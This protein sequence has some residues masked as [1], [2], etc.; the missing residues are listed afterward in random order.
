MEN[1]TLYHHGI[2]GQKWGKRNGP[3]YPLKPEDH[4]KAEKEATK[5]K[6]QVSDN[7]KKAIKIGAAIVATGL[8]AY[9][10]YKVG[11][12]D[13][14]TAIGKQYAKSHELLGFSSDI[15]GQK[16]ERASDKVREALKDVNP[17]GERFHCAQNSL[18]SCIKFSG[19]KGLENIR[20]KPGIRLDTRGKL[21]ETCFLK[22]DGSPAKAIQIKDEI[23]TVDDAIKAI[24][25][26]FNPK[27]GSCGM[28]EAPLQRRLNGHAVMWYMEDNNIKF[29]DPFFVDITNPKKSGYVIMEDASVYFGTALY[30][31]YVSISCL[32]GL[33]P[34][35][36]S[37][38]KYF[39]I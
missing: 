36:D 6:I 26:E 19:I 8:I 28:L 7:T 32:D 22:S 16:L 39:D 13:K 11:A 14:L 15:S 4:S 18:A 17:S 31:K 24:I 21:F 38:K 27:N 23:N 35:I 34:N 9:G 25:K 5:K 30:N 10:G 37:I 2:L 1:R 12:L 29:A 33:E 3:P 20:T